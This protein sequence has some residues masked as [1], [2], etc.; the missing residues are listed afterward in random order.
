[1]RLDRLLANLGYGTRSEVRELVL[2]GRV[3]LQ[4]EPVL[5]PAAKVDDPTGVTLDGEPLEAPTGLFVAFHKPVGYVCSHDDRHDA[6]VWELLPRHWLARNPRPTTVGRLDKDS[7]GLLLITDLHPLVHRLTSPRRHVPKRYVVRLD[8]P[9]DDPGALAALFASGTLVLRG[10]TEPCLP[11]ELIVRDDGGE[12]AGRVVE[13]VLTEGRHRQLRRMFAACGYRVEALHRVAV[14]PY[15]LGD[16]PE[17][18]WR[19]ED[20]AAVTDG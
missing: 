19:Y 3:A 9:L 18:G 5:D 6:V 11:A 8:R 7:S 12:G 16:L 1:M 4:G 2:A 15:E 17:G 10:E 20:P 14:G 13:V